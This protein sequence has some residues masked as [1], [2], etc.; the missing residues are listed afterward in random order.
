MYITRRY[1]ISIKRVLQKVCPFKKPC[2]FAVC[3]SNIIKYN[4]FK[5][6]VY[7]LYIKPLKDIY[8]C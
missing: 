4:Y 2:Y 6:F 8:I 7:Y 5:M 1:V 3:V